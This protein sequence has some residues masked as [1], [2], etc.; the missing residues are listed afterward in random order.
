MNAFQKLGHE[1]EKTKKKLA[2]QAKLTRQL[3]EE[4][5]KYSAATEELNKQLQSIETETQKLLEEKSV[6]EGR[7]G[8]TVMWDSANA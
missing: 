3:S 6:A 5:Q 7:Y 2:E 4:K 8:Y 1:R